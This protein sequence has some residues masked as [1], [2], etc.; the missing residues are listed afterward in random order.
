MFSKIIKTNEEI[1]DIYTIYVERIKDYL[2]KVAD[3]N[4]IGFFCKS[5]N[6]ESIYAYVYWIMTV[7]LLEMDIKDEILEELKNKLEIC[8][9]EDGLCWDENIINLGYLNGD[10]WG[11]RHF[12]P[13]YFIAT[14]R[15]NMDLKYQL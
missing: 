8:Q 9:K 5:T 15:L 13:Q 4:R 3:D 6:K 7:S 1:E 11:A 2:Y 14:E 12:M 10:G